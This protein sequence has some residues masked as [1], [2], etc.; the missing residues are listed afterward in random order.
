MISK[1]GVLLVNLGTP[2]SPGVRDVYRYLIEFLTDKRVIDLPWILRQ[3][4]VRGRIV[5]F[6]VRQSSNFYKKIWTKE[7]SP[8]FVFGKKLKENLQ[9][10]LGSRFVVELGMRYQ[11]PSIEKSLENLLKAGIDK[12]L[13][14]PLFPQYASATTGSVHESVMNSLSKYTVIPKVTFVDQFATHP[15]F[16]NAFK[17]VGQ[18]Y[19]IKSY[20]HVI[21]SFHGLPQ[22]QIKKA[23]RFGHC[24]K[25][26]CCQSICSSNQSCYSAQ[27]FASAFAIAKELKMAKDQFSVCFQSRLGSDPWLQPYTSTIIHDLAKQGK[28]R[29]LVFCPSFVCDCLE[30]IYEIGVEYNKEFQEAGGEHLELVTG[31]NDHPLWV[32]GLKSMVLEH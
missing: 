18:T 23:D 20:D 9:Q 2:D 3:L 27:C 16:I 13:V 25:K 21:L 30:T 7:G 22:R 10:E 14:I 28:K 29:V 31:L 17:A 8:L 11:N 19:D 4:L 32:S 6:R 15:G 5:P 12:L 24:L 1:T 26:E